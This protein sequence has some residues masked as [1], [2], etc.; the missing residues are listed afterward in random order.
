MKEALSAGKFFHGAATN[1]KKNGDSYPVEWNISPVFDNDGT[2]THYLSIQK[3]LSNLKN[4]VSRL[5]NTN[6]HFREFLVDIADTAESGQSSE[7]MNTLQNRK[8]VIAEELLENRVLYTPELR[9]DQN[10]NLFEED[11]FFDCSH[12]LKGMLSEATV[13][14]EI[15]SA[16]AYC[17]RLKSSNSMRN[18]LSIVKDTNDRIELLPYSKNLTADMREVGQNIHDIAN[19]IFFFD[20]FLGISTVLAQLANQTLNYTHDA[21]NPILTTTYRE[22]MSDLETWV[23]I[24]F[25]DKSAKNIHE[26]DASIISSAKQLLF[27]LEWHDRD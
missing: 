12:E 15:I 4:I 25:I 7:L 26:L 23:N 20:D 9:S 24:V 21:L 1:Y 17:S 6:E 5:K 13:A 18:L 27:F 14:I 2:I 10:I 8:Q 3:D 16:Q 22:L 19:E 11:E